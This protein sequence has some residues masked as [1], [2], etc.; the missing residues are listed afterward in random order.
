ME[1]QEAEK[2]VFKLSD[3]SIVMIRELIQ[4]SLLTGTNVVDHL[5]AFRCEEIKTDTVTRYLSPSEEYVGAYNEMI[6]KL[7]EE[8]MRKAKE[9]Q[10]KL[11]SPE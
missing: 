8:S 7:N 2:V 11:A 5:R 1:D 10:E 6:A 4:L 9:A 3:D